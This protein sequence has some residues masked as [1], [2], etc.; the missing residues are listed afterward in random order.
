MSDCE[1]VSLEWIT[2]TG[3]STGRRINVLVLV[4]VTVNAPLILTEVL[5]VVSMQMQLY[6]LMSSI[7]KQWGCDC[8]RTT[9]QQVAGTDDRA[10]AGMLT[11][12][13]AVAPAVLV[14][15][16]RLR[17]LTCR[18]WVARHTVHDVVDRLTCERVDSVTRAASHT[19][20]TDDDSRQMSTSTTMSHTHNV[21][22]NSILL[23]KKVKIRRE[24]LLMKLQLRATG[25]HLPYE[26]TQCYLTSDT[27]EHSPP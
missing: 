11:S 23:V 27:S 9:G 16:R 10:P 8:D 21:T 5:V 19:P 18:S 22:S 25:C 3:T 15:C 6:W 17:V 14:A 7:R 26:I 1:G 20:L 12:S 2:C 4:Q 13:V 24:E